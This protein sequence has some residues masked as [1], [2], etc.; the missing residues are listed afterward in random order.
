[1][2]ALTVNTKLFDLFT[3]VIVILQELP[4]LYR[5]HESAL[6]EI[7]G[8]RLNSTQYIENYAID[9]LKSS[10]E[11]IVS[12]NSGCA[13][14][15]RDIAQAYIKLAYYIQNNDNEAYL[16]DFVLF[17][18]RAMRMNSADARKLFPCILML[19]NI[20]T[21]AETFLKEVGNTSSKRYRTHDN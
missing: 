17:V 12:D 9:K 13:D 4:E 10:I 5:T 16:D 21:V 11:E 18:L 14:V 3:R 8:S 7:L 15:L 19:D 2:T 1:M 20:A 6:T